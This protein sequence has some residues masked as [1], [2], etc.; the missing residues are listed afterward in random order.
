MYFCCY[1]PTWRGGLTS[2]IRL[3]AV[4][5]T[6]TPWRLA[7]SPR[8]ICACC[9]KSHKNTLSSFFKKQT[10]KQMD[11]DSLTRKRSSSGSFTDELTYC[12]SHHIRNSC[13]NQSNHSHRILH[14]LDYCNHNCHNCHSL[15]SNSCHNLGSSFGWDLEFNEI[16]WNNGHYERQSNIQEGD[17]HIK[18]PPR[19]SLWCVF[20]YSIVLFSKTKQNL[21]IFL[22]VHSLIHSPPPL[23]RDLDK[24]PP[25]PPQYCCCWYCSLDMA[26]FISH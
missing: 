26:T 12:H 6:T 16:T 10:N 7:I 21:D 3:V 18:L 2:L 9:T 17:K 8:L 1:I 14:I 15:D 5:V 25:L 24:Y 13:C 19:V 4:G 11:N 20:S 23:P 22:K